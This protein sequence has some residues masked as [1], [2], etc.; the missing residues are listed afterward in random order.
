[1]GHPEDSLEAK[2]DSSFLPNQAQR[3]W[4]P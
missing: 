4:A 1:L 2:K 3:H